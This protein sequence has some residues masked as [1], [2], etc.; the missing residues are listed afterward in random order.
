MSGSAKIDSST[1][2]D[3]IAVAALDTEYQA[4]VQRNDAAAMDRLLADDFVLI[5]GTG[6]VITKADLVED[7][8][9]RNV[10]YE[11]QDDSQQVVRVWGDTA[12]ITALLWV[13]GT[14]KGA[15]FEYKLWFSDV[16]LRTEGGWKYTFAQASARAAVQL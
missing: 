14:E 6:R 10:I 13:K 1:L 5:T 2:D 7:A 4:A 3:Q 11:R 8:R 15:P 16:Y 12:V 9:K